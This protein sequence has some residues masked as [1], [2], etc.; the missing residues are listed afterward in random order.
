MRCISLSCGFNFAYVHFC[1]EINLPVWPKN[2]WNRRE[3]QLNNASATHNTSIIRQAVLMQGN[4]QFMY[5]MDDSSTLPWQHIIFASVVNAKREW[6]AL[7]YAVHSTMYARTNPLPTTILL[8]LAAENSC[9][10]VVGLLFFFFSSFDWN[11]DSS[12]EETN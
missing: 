6:R 7:D 2:N 3:V 5:A 1:F 9:S 4:K 12:Y 10:S 8:F 11:F